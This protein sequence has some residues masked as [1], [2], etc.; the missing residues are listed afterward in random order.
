M[1]ETSNNSVDTETEIANQSLTSPSSGTDSISTAE[2]SGASQQAETPSTQATSPADAAPAASSPSD[3]VA[4]QNAGETGVPDGN[5]SDPFEKRWQDTRN[6]AN[7][8]HQAN[9]ELKRQ[10]EQLQ[11]QFQDIRQQYA[12]VKPDELEQWRQSRALKPWDEGSP[13]HQDFLRLVDKAEYFDDLARRVKDPQQ[14]QQMQQLAAESIGPKGL[15]MLEA[16]KADVRNQER[17]RRLNPRAYYQK[18]IREQAQPVVRETLQTTNQEYQKAIQGKEAA[19][20][21]MSNKEVATPQNI[22][23]V[24]KYMQESGMPF[25]VASAIVERDHYRSRVSQADKVRQSAEEKERLLQGNAAGTVAR[26]PNSSKKVDV[27]QYLK[28]KGVTNSRA[29]IDE[30]FELDKKGLL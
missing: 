29:T 24:L 28:D 11:Q 8:V 5:P 1:S 9:L 21:W 7:E 17:E 4:S 30:L 14:L 3:G 15:E 10:H 19:Q 23:T 26:N 6:W 2:P 13:E 20:K 16:W 18:L 22:Q 25:E 27:K 12:G